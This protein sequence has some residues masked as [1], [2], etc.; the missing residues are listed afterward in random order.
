M[1]ST[2]ASS[3]NRWGIAFAGIIVM[4]CLGTVYSWSL[5][6]NSLVAGLGL[7][8]QDA[9]FAFETAIFCLGLGAVSADAG[10][11]ASDRAP[12]R[13]SASSFGGSA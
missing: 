12:L 3:G 2:T 11:T 6:T 10:K 9:T 7:S 1:A 8:T 4:I 13:L 5:F